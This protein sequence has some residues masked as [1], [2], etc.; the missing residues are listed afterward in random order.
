MIREDEN[1]KSKTDWL[2]GHKSNQKYNSANST[3]K[4]PDE[5]KKIKK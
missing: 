3:N 5:N 2:D 1:N 4:A